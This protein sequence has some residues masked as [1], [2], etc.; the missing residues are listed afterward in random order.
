MHCKTKLPLPHRGWNGNELHQGSVA[1][2]AELDIVGVIFNITAARGGRSEVCIY[3]I[4]EPSL[5]F[6]LFLFVL[7]FFFFKSNRKVPVESYSRM[8]KT[9]PGG[10]PGI[11][12]IL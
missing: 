3:R 9:A 6:L 12:I 8:A 2:A 10:S 11:S 5:P 4:G 7:F 1:R